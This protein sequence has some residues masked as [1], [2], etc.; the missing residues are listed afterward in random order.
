MYITNQQ[1]AEELREF[2]KAYFTKTHRMTPNTFPDLFNT[3]D[4]ATK[5]YLH[6]QKEGKEPDETITKELERTGCKNI[7]IV[8]KEYEIQVT[9]DTDEIPS[10]TKEISDYTHTGIMNNS[11]DAPG[12]FIIAFTLQKKA[13]CCDGGGLKDSLILCENCSCHHPKTQEIE[14]LE[15]DLYVSRTK[16]VYLKVKEKA[17]DAGHGDIFKKI[18]PDYK[19]WHDKGDSLTPHG[20]QVVVDKI[21][22]TCGKFN[23]LLKKKGL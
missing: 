3:I 5:A 1:K 16:E 13:E 8:D 9:F 4:A 22:E 21:N 20:E 10:F 14:L 7:C 11:T 18:Y 15:I 12:V 2:I 6:S 23:K 19:T 17:M